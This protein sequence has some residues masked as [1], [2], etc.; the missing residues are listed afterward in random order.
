MVVEISKLY[1][2]KSPA[3]RDKMEV[4]EVVVLNRRKLWIEDFAGLLKYY[5][6]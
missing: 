2:F 4:A 3:L 6:F 1:L 5:L